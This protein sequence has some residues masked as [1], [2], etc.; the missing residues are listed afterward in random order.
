MKILDPK[1][2]TKL[3]IVDITLFWY[4]VSMSHEH[5]LMYFKYLKIVNNHSHGLLKNVQCINCKVYF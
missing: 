1:Y 5:I 3:I 4:Y 2:F